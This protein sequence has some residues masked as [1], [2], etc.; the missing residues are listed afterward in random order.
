[1]AL[2]FVTVP[3]GAIP[4]QLDPGTSA[5]VFVQNM[6]QRHCVV[7]PYGDLLSPSGT[8]TYMVTSGAAVTVESNDGTTVGYSVSGTATSRGGAVSLDS[9]AFTGTPTLNGVPLAATFASIDSPAFTGTPTLDGTPLGGGSS[10]PS[11][12]PQVVFQPLDFATT[13][14]YARFSFLV[15]ST[16]QDLTG[17][18]YKQTGFIDGIVFES[19]GAAAL[20]AAPGH[21]GSS[22]MSIQSLRTAHYAGTMVIGVQLVSPTG[23][24]GPMVT[25]APAFYP[26][27]NPGTLP[28]AAAIQRGRTYAV[29]TPGAA[30][31]FYTCLLGSDGVTYEWV[32]IAGP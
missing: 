21:L 18:E 14:G 9:P 25:S 4:V 23:D 10:S 6:G 20:L 13:L 3:A 15:G 26:G 22:V 17:W 12:F 5:S 24:V 32:Q 30:D 1:V 27:A 2:S 19:D 16:G 31:K 28:D 8:A 11:T 29:P 7:L